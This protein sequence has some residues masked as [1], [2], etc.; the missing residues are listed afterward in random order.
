M[1]ELRWHGR[2]E[3]GVSA[4]SLGDRSVP[5]Q[6]R[7][8]HEGGAYAAGEVFGDWKGCTISRP[9]ESGI[10]IQ[11]SSD[12]SYRIISSQDYLHRVHPKGTTN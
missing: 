10:C 7:L 8:N 3:P 9:S 11:L 1:R 2:K 6:R 5:L 12:P 4:E